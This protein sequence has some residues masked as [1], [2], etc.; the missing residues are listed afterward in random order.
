MAFR[1]PQVNFSKGELADELLGRFDVSAYQAGLRKARNV[2]IL[3]Y[4]G[5]AKRPGTRFVAEVFDASE[6]VRLIPFQFSIEQAYALELGQGYMRPAALGGIVLE[7]ELAITDI[8]Q[9]NPAQIE[10][11]FHD[12]V[13]GDQIY[14]TGI[15]GMTELNGRTFTVLASIDDD[16]FT[17]DVDSS[18][19]GAFVSASGGITRTE[20]PDAV[21][22]PTVPAVVP[23]PPPPPVYG[24]GYGY[25]FYF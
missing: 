14:L 2:T 6:P 22:P 24:G 9:A 12:Y 23:P 4:G 19:F 21:V 5:I 10:A 13:A 7:E 18:E 16:H 8:T 1:A 3:K 17:I 11:A 15:V 20:A 25:G